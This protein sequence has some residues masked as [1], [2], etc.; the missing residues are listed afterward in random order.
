ML[1]ITD[2]T[3]NIIFYSG[4]TLLVAGG[5]LVYL[6]WPEFEA[7]PNYQRLAALIPLATSHPMLQVDRY[8][9]WSSVQG[10]DRGRAI[11][12]LLL[13]VVLVIGSLAWML[14]APNE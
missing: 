1:A 8:R 12:A 11:G 7:L 14:V 2:R 6:L 4:A 10:L 13:P 5:A 3:R 9:N